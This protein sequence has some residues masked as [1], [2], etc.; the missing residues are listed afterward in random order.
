MSWP[1]EDPSWLIGS[2]DVARQERRVGDAIGIAI[3][4]AE[5]EVDKDRPHVGL[6]VDEGLVER[7]GAYGAGRRMPDTR[8][9][10]ERLLVRGEVTPVLGDHPFADLLQGDRA[11]IIAAGAVST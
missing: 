10:Y 6:D 3:C 7:I 2:G 9:R 5:E 1:T 4:I 11:P 8:K